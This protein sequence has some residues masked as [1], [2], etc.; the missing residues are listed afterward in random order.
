MNQENLCTFYQCFL[1]F[2][3]HQCA[4]FI[5]VA[6]TSK[7]SLKTKGWKNDL[8]CT[9]TCREIEVTLFWLTDFFLISNCKVFDKYPDKIQ[10]VP[11][12]KICPRLKCSYLL[13]KKIKNDSLAIDKIFCPRTRMKSIP[14]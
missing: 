4:P 2:L 13:V 14:P 1:P 8:A 11:D 5:M 7:L 6:H 12:K 3:L 10:N 9:N